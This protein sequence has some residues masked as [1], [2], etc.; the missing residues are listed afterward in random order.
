MEAMLAQWSASGRLRVGSVAPR[1]NPELRAGQI[2]RPPPNNQRGPAFPALETALARAQKAYDMAGV[3]HRAADAKRKAAQNALDQYLEQGGQKKKKK[4][5]PSEEELR[6]TLSAREEAVAPFRTALDSARAARDVADGQ[7]RQVRA[8][9]ESAAK[10]E[11]AVALEARLRSIHLRATGRH[12]PCRMPGLLD[13]AREQVRNHPEQLWLGVDDLRRALLQLSATKEEDLGGLHRLLHRVE[14]AER[15]DPEAQRR[16]Y[17]A[18]PP[19]GLVSYVALRK[20]AES[21]DARND[22][23]ADEEHP[24]P[25][26]KTQLVTPTPPPRAPPQRQRPE[27]ARPHRRL[28][29]PSGPQVHHRPAPVR[30]QSARR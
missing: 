8:K 11:R 18:S 12:L 17:E 25:Q 29:E 1:P 10:F 6:A 19:Q 14:Q 20:H 23:R 2:R 26:H 3:R 21:A 24:E 30:P 7:L 22:L 16:L 27:S 28:R 5:E 4:G 15:A 9:A 13:K